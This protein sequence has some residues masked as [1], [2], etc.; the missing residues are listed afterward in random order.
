MK[1]DRLSQALNSFAEVE[2]DIVEF[3]RVGDAG[4]AADL[5]RLRRQLVAEFA[6]L[7]SAL[8]T[9]P[10]V[11]RDADTK[12]EILRLFSAFRAANSINTAEW[13]VI[14]V[15]DHITEYKVAVQSVGKA[16]EAFWRRIQTLLD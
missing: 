12:T 9:A 7:G 5:I 14:R 4:T 15:R 11:A 13:P 16:S 6:K 1:S 10:C 2:R 8:E 3:G